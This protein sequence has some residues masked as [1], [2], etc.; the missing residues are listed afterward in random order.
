LSQL[1]VL[2]LAIDRAA[3]GGVSGSA[4][5][6]VVFFSFDR[7]KVVWLPFL[8]LITKLLNAFVAP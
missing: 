3:L 7:T 8:F 6:Q 2:S 5:G 4:D 1:A